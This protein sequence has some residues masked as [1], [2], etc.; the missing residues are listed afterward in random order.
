MVGFIS[1][2][3]I[4]GDFNRRMHAIDNTFG[5]DDESHSICKTKY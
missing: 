2:C 1:Q 4:Y 5:P 3:K